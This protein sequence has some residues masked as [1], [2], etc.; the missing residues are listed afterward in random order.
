MSLN[1]LKAYSYYLI[2]IFYL[3]VG[4]IVPTLCFLNRIRMK[5][6]IIIPVIFTANKVSEMTLN[7]ELIMV[8][9]V[10]EIESTYKY[11]CLIFSF[12]AAEIHFL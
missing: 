7:S 5:R 3:S 1:Q 9:R 11:I 6:R 2:V 8:G 12:F 4:S 10:K